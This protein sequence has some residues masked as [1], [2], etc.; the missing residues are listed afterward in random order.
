[1]G[2]SALELFPFAVVLAEEGDTCRPWWGYGQ[3]MVAMRHKL[4]HVVC[5]MVPDLETI[6]GI[7]HADSDLG[8]C[9]KVVLL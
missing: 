4:E 8:A 7:F 2:R 1:M 5:V 3:R 9:R 6:F